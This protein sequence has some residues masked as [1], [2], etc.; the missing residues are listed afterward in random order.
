MDMS[1]S[2]AKR[3]YVK[4]LEHVEACLQ[5]KEAKWGARGDDKLGGE[6]RRV[7]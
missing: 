6:G 3:N 5:A 1:L 2:R 4:S 7:L